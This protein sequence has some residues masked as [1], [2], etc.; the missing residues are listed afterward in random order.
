MATVR[1]TRRKA[2]QV[3]PNATASRVRQRTSAAQAAVQ[4]FANGVAQDLRAKHAAGLPYST[5]N[6][7]GEVVFVHPDGT[8]RTGRSADSPAVS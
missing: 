4:A 5:L 7:R 6:A 3:T 2:D 8:V 1:R